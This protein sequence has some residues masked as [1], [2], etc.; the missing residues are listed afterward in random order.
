MPP[1]DLSSLRLLA[2]VARTGSISAAAKELG[3]SQQAAS[4]RMHRLEA[5]VGLT[6]LTRSTRGSALTSAGATTAAWAAEVA[7]SAERFE[8]GV[9]ALRAGNAGPLRVA[10]SLTITDYL[11]PRW[12]MA[13]R[14]TDAGI[15][16]A[17]TTGNSEHVVEAVVSGGVDLGFIESPLELGE[18]GELAAT[19][20]ARDELVVV[21]AP[22]HPWAG[23]RDI[24]AAELAR[25]P[26]IAREPGSGTRLAAEQ[27]LAEAGHPPVPP[28]A[29]LP[30]TAAIRTTV[31]AGAGPSV[32]SI[33]AVR[34][35]LAAGRLVRVRVRGI[36]FVRE[37]RAVYRE[38]AQ[39]SGPA[40]ALLE[41]IA[42]ATAH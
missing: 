9:A 28:L 14:E 33:L 17:V 42:R 38:G 11:L 3:I 37:L 25:T 21:V 12:L 30:A 31:A 6:L 24:G 26:L 20:L 16:V 34:D 8:A 7:D 1:V 5:S 18:R 41:A 35:D 39:R 4:V 36:R 27:M 15:R 13:L 2:A 22:G 19:T 23:R 29:E 32:L 40:A 10:A